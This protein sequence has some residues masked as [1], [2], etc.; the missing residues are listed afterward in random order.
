VARVFHPMPEDADAQS[1]VH[2]TIPKEIYNRFRTKF[3]HNGM[4]QYA[5]RLIIEMLPEMAD[6]D[7]A[8]KE[9]AIVHMQSMFAADRAK[10]EAD[11]RPRITPVDARSPLDAPE[12]SSLDDADDILN[13]LGGDF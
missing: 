3:P 6:R 2:A 13:E 5:I 9:I 12:S 8:Y 7:E 10:W 1:R 11:K 4:I